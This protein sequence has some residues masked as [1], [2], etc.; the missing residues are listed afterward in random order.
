M[1]H[2]LIFGSDCPLT[3]PGVAWR[4][5]ETQVRDDRLLERIG[6]ESALEVFGPFEATTKRV[7]A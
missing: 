1:P 4:F 7:A 6:R 5:L 3:H 2:K